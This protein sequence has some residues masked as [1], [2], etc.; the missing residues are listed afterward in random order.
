MD[1]ADWLV[2][3]QA[4]QWLAQHQRVALATVVRTWG[5]APRPVG[6]FV[7]L[8]A[9]GLVVGSVS[10][11]C[12]E[13][14]LS[15]RA[16]EGT[17]FNDAPQRVRYGVNAD[18]ANRL[19]LPCGGTLELVIETLRSPDELSA[20]IAHLQAGHTVRRH[21]DL[22]SGA[23]QLEAD[24]PPAAL[25]LSDSALITTHGPQLRLILIGA[26]QLTHY[27]A[28]LAVACDYAVIVCDP[29]EETASTWN[30]PGT[31]L[32]RTMPD[33]TVIALK[34]D[35]RTAVI[36]LTHDP[37]LDD[38]ALMET[39]K[40]DAFYVGAIGSRANQVKRRERLLEFGV[41]PEQLTR[42][43]GPVGLSIG[44][45]TPAEIAV[46]ILAQLTA[47]RYGVALTKI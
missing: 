42:L 28:H 19:G 29:R 32:L 37:K 38:L 27:V 39:L 3:Q 6:A 14:V 45:R 16:R 31:E 21:L 34:P 20:F 22:A 47:V 41:T 17:L 4:Q 24:V 43:Q 7:A 12:I 36:A 13:D 26:N 9:D 1:H 40:S 35:A 11:G 44:A 2:L 10:G 23:V 30:V 15:A 33:D 18:E 5:S 8:N 46:A 25:T